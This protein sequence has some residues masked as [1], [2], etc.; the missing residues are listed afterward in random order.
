VLSPE[1][2]DGQAW[3]VEVIQPDRPAARY[4]ITEA[5]RRVVRSEYELPDG[6][7]FQI[8]TVAGS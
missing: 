2:G 4:W 7:R 8:E 5:P 3:V 1:L 6:G